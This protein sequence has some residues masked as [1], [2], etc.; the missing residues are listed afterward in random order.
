MVCR[1][2]GITETCPGY[3]ANLFLLFEMDVRSRQDK[4]YTRL[5]S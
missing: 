1:E 4:Y 2:H 5:H 3:F